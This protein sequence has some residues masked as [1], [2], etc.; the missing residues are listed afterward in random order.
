M[1]SKLKELSKTLKSD[2]NLNQTELI[3]FFNEL[4]SWLNTGFNKSRPLQKSLVIKYTE[5]SILKVCDIDLDIF[6]NLL[7]T[8][9]K[10]LIILIHPLTDKKIR[11]SIWR[12]TLQLIDSKVGYLAYNSWLPLLTAAF[13]NKPRDPNFNS[14]T[15][16]TFSYEANCNLFLIHLHYIMTYFDNILFLNTHQII[17]KRIVYHWEI[18]SELMFDYFDSP[19]PQHRK[20]Y[21]YL[22]INCL[23]AINKCQKMLNISFFNLKYTNTKMVSFI[24]HILNNI[25]Y[26]YSETLDQEATSLA[27]S[28]FEATFPCNIAT[29][30]PED[31]SLTNCD[32]INAIIEKIKPKINLNYVNVE[33]SQQ[34]NI[35]PFLLGYFIS[36]PSSKVLEMI[37]LLAQKLDDYPVF[38]INLILI[39]TNLVY[40]LLLRIKAVKDQINATYFVSATTNSND[41]KAANQMYL[42]F[43]STNLNSTL[44]THLA[45]LFQHSLRLRT[46]IQSFFKQKVDP[47]TVSAILA[48]LFNI[49][50]QEMVPFIAT[51]FTS[52]LFDSQIINVQQI[53]NYLV[54]LATNPIDSSYMPN[55]F[56]RIA[57]QMTVT[58]SSLILSLPPQCS[59]DISSKSI[60]FESHDITNRAMTEIGGISIKEIFLYFPF[61]SSEF[62]KETACNFLT[63]LILSFDPFFNNYISISITGAL[64]AVIDW[65]NHGQKM[66]SKTQKNKPNK[67]EQPKNI[68]NEL[69]SGALFYQPNTSLSPPPTLLEGRN[70]SNSSTDDL[71][72]DYDEVST[73][74]AFYHNDCIIDA[75]IKSKIVDL[76]FLF[77]FLL[78]YLMNSFVKTLKPTA[79]DVDELNKNSDYFLKWFINSPSFS[80]KNNESEIKNLKFN[81][82]KKMQKVCFKM[83]RSAIKVA[84]D[85]DL[86]RNSLARD[87]CR[88][89][90]L[91][92]EYTIKT[93]NEP[94]DKDLV[95][96]VIE[97]I[98]AGFPFSFSLIPLLSQSF[99]TIKFDS[100]TKQERLKVVNYLTSVYLMISKSIEKET[101]SQ[102]KTKL[103]LSPLADTNDQCTFIDIRADSLA[104][105]TRAFENFDDI[106]DFIDCA[107]FSLFI[108]D[109]YSSQTNVFG[110]V[111]TLVFS[112]LSHFEKI[113]SVTFCH[114][115]ILLFPTH[116]DLI[117]QKCT[118]S[119]FNKL[120][121]I[122]FNVLLKQIYKSVEIYDLLTQYLVDIMLILKSGP[123]FN[124][125]LAFI[126]IE[127]LPN[128]NHILSER[129][130]YLIA[131]LKKP[132]GVIEVDL[133][134][135]SYY[136]ISNRG[137]IYCI[138]N[139]SINNDSIIVECSL[140]LGSS[141]YRI[142]STTE[143]TLPHHYS[144]VQNS[145][146]T[147]H[148]YMFSP[149]P[150]TA[151]FFK[152]LSHFS[153]STL[154]FST[155]LNSNINPSNDLAVNYAKT[156]P[157]PTRISS[158]VT[159]SSNKINN[160]LDDIDN[161]NLLNNIEDGNDSTNESSLCINH[162]N[163]IKSRSMT[164]LSE[165]ESESCGKDLSTE[166]QL[167][168]QRSQR[169]SIT[170]GILY[171][172]TND[173]LNLNADICIHKEQAFL[174][175]DILLSDYTTIDDNSR[176]LAQEPFEKTSKNFQ[177]FVTSIG[178]FQKRQ[179][180]DSILDVNYVDEHNNV[181]FIVG[182]LS[183]CHLDAK[184]IINHYKLINAWKPIKHC[185]VFIIWNEDNTNFDINDGIT[186]SYYDQ[187]IDCE[188]YY[189]KINNLSPKVFIVVTPIRNNLFKVSIIEHFP[190]KS[191]NCDLLNKIKM[192]SGPMFGTTIVPKKCL[193]EL[194][195]STA[196]YETIKLAQL[197]EMKEKEE[198]LKKTQQEIEMK[199]RTRR[200]NHSNDSSPTIQVTK[201]KLCLTDPEFFD[202][203]YNEFPISFTLDF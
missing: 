189:D 175:N 190:D 163:A 55:L 159:V 46:L 192:V 130:Q 6:V 27:F 97:S 26:L 166:I 167:L 162:K 72:Y 171:L 9:M 99:C 37:D 98:L 151:L 25:N 100:F 7:P 11:E 77:G 82:T 170:I 51:Y 180:D 10:I 121:D 85:F 44:L 110:M 52:I 132:N 24:L 134:D 92:I 182:P 32:T 111:E 29:T 122:P 145:A 141:R 93:A 138:Q 154:K 4:L 142:S 33:P 94:L 169:Q 194:V 57:S 79:K 58:L 23:Q 131:N 8:I 64:L 191:S 20:S 3:D 112:R 161:S 136:S 28:F 179:N 148:S 42:Q 133:S 172:K 67:S 80:S 125:T 201:K 147:H 81:D 164:F 61:N 185:K 70:Q 59:A 153:Q 165:Q 140:P 60:F 168:F 78:P 135:H 49:Q 38:Q 18:I 12:R 15:P 35:N 101:V 74:D 198:S 176:I 108:A 19:L 40:P 178:S 43:I 88:L 155:N 96:A 203:L 195:R 158:L 48:S 30:N 186:T 199:R 137:T 124:K 34:F 65:M 2:S 13:S 119:L 113:P 84:F 187:S 200:H 202:D 5:M 50:K 31:S 115:L 16:S 75:T 53:T 104:V 188:T 47:T 160:F 90:A 114:H 36:T 174:L 109:L 183:V 144:L 118:K 127:N 91:Y 128:E 120:I 193:G 123:L 116:Y 66:Y 71:M 197:I 184:P 117:V 181:V 14:G 95:F 39:M 150:S 22:T 177:E 86:L 21:D 73:V 156:P 152:V 143:M 54:L 106:S 107:A 126:T 157:K 196:I 129:T 89:L 87:W 41:I 68:F 56:A 173:V 105:L 139:D 76:S 149:A 102:L 1:T 146:T 69:P 45:Q 103:G 62:T 17:L 83:L 63:N